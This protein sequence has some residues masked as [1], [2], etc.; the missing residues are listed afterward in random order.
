MS[1]ERLAAAADI[2]VSTLEKC[3]S[4]ERRFSLRTIAK[5]EAALKVS[6]IAQ[7]SAHAPEHLGD[8]NEARFAVHEIMLSAMTDMLGPVS[9]GHLVHAMA[10]ALRTR[11]CA[12]NDA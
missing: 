4:G 11:T 5:L 9:P 7:V 12:A 8:L 3:V 6:L 2:S 1:H 10:A